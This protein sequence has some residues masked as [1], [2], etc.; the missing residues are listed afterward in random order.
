MIF[1]PYTVYN[2]YDDDDKN[3]RSNQRKISCIIAN[4]RIILLPTVMGTKIT[5]CPT[6]GSRSVVASKIER[7]FYSNKV[8]VKFGL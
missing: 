8:R 6:K 3:S 4:V 2:K 1:R 7:S 5:D